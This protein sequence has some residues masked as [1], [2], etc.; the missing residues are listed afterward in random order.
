[1]VPKDRLLPSLL[2]RLTDE[3]PDVRTAE[4]DGFSFD[5]EAYRSAVFRDLDW[6][7]NTVAPARPEEIADFPQAAAST[8]NYGVL[9]FAGTSAVTVE[10][11]VLEKRFREAVQRFEPR[12]LPE[13]VKV[14]V[15]VSPD[16]MSHRAVTFRLEG[17]LWARPVPEEIYVKTR[18]DLETGRITVHEVATRGR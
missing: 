2:D 15:E 13:S 14:R 3:A 11:R 4:A 7:L 6:L 18:M 12:I 9:A 5:L 17:V 10:A 16:V 8:V 1:V